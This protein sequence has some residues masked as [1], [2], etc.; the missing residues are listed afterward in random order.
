MISSIN[1]FYYLLVTF[2]IFFLVQASSATKLDNT[3]CPAVESCL[4]GGDIC[5]VLE[6]PKHELRPL[7]SADEY[8]LTELRKGVYSFYEGVS[9]SQILIDRSAGRLAI[10]DFPRT[11]LSVFPSNGSS[12]L[13]H[14]IGV[15]IKQTTIRRVDLVYTHR[16]MDHIGGAAAI[17]QFIKTNLFRTLRFP[18]LVWGTKETRRFL[19][20]TKA[21]RM[22]MPQVNI[23]IYSKVGRTMDFND[24]IVMKMIVVT[25]HSHNDAITLIPRSRNGQ[26]G[27]IHTVDYVRPGSVPFFNFALAIE[28]ADYIKTQKE[29]LRLPFDILI[30]GHGRLG[31]KEDV[32]INLN[33]VQDVIQFIKEGNAEVT[34]QQQID[35]GLTRIGDPSAPQ[36]LNGEFATAVGV[37]LGITN[38]HAK[39]IRKYGC[40]LASTTEYGRSHCF[41]ANFYV[42]LD[43][44]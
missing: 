30:P 29:I 41:T 24:D 38:C 26:K 21:L 27:I 1:A 9:Y 10:V 13:V 2:N 6:V 15:L 16:H 34:M 37:A 35:A 3:S 36:F 5:S 4:S 40:K 43:V 11:P 25:G 44:F 23:L 39:I 14:A 8:T 18:P 22:N 19:R 31:S 28:L 32:K 42:L 17:A 12:K 33:Y 20:S 7:L